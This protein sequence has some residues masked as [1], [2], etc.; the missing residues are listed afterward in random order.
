MICVLVFPR[1]DFVYFYRI[2]CFCVLIK[3][4]YC[5]VWFLCFVSFEFTFVFVVFF[6]FFFGSLLCVLLVLDFFIIYRVAFLFMV[7][8]MKMRKCTD[9]CLYGRCKNNYLL[10]GNKVQLYFTENNSRY[11]ICRVTRDK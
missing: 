4:F 10:T 2:F 11:F 8:C 6:G 7:M 1:A 5:V 3:C 9:A